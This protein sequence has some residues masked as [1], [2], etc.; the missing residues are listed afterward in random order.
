MIGETILNISAKSFSFEKIYTN[1]NGRIYYWDNVKTLLIFFV[2]LGHLLIPVFKDSRVLSYVYYFIYFFHMPAFVFVSGYFSKSYMKKGSSKINR[3]A[4]YF[5]L[6]IVFKFIDYVAAYLIYS[7]R[8]ALNLFYDIGAPWYLMAMFF[9]MLMLPIFDKLGAKI[10]IAASVIV[11]LTIGFF[12]TIGTFLSAARVLNFLPFFLLGYFFTKENTEKLFAKKN[13]II[14]CIVLL[15]FAI[16]IITCTGIIT[17]HAT[18]LYGLT[19][20]SLYQVPK[21]YYGIFLR[22]LWYCISFI[23]S[24]SVLCLIPRFKLSVSYIGSR[25]LSIYIL[26][27]AFRDLLFHYG[28]FKHFDD[29]GLTLLVVL[30]ITSIILCLVLA[31][32]YIFL[33]FEKI[34]KIKIIKRDS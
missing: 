13:K 26:H 10:S 19:S 15:V 17:K 8:P 3:L 24:F 7:N 29:C 5:L 30:T 18:V 28:V 11:A 33:P 1:E 14:A 16:F 2:V 23:V 31:N 27:R 32:K 25:T 4:G 9:W 6:Y 12:P 20:Y 34:M 21:L 22:F